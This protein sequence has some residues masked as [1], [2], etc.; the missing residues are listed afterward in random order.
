MEAMEQGPDKLDAV[1][2][3]PRPLAQQRHLDCWKFPSALAAE[4]TDWLTGLCR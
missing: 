1:R 3:Q 2:Q 4:L